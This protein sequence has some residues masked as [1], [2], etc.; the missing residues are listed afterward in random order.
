MEDYRKDEI[1]YDE[2]WQ[3]FDEPV[4]QIEKS[5]S[6]EEAVPD[7]KDKTKKETR[8]LP[9]ITIQL[10]ICLIIAFVLFI[11]KAM[12]SDFYKDIS[13][14]YSEQMQNTLLSNETFE[15]IDLSKYFPATSD[16]VATIDES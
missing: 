8:R 2:N 1:V 6:I 11:L 15:D 12:N 3:R 5:D 13:L 14:W 16:E 10:I 7:K 4:V 9:L